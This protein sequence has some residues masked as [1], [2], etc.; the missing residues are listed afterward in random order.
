MQRSQRIINAPNKFSP[1]QPHLY[2]QENYLLR[3]EDNNELLI[4]KRSSINSIVDDRAILGT[5]AK[6]RYAVIEA[7][8]SYSQC[9]D[10]YEQMQS[11]EKTT[12]DDGRDEID[13]RQSDVQSD[14]DLNDSDARNDMPSTL[15]LFFSSTSD[16]T[17]F[18]F[19]FLRAITINSEKKEVVRICCTTK[20]TLYDTYPGRTFRPPDPTGSTRKAPL[21]RLIPASSDHIQQIPDGKPPPN[22]TAQ[23][24]HKPTET[25]EN[26]N[27]PKFARIFP[28]K[29]TLFRQQYT[30]TT[31]SESRTPPI[32]NRNPCKPR[33]RK[34]PGE[35]INPQFPSFPSFFHHQYP[36]PAIKITYKTPYYATVLPNNSSQTPKATQN[37]THK[38][39]MNATTK[40]RD[41]NPRYSLQQ[42]QNNQNPKAIL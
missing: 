2:S 17:C 3:F 26:A 22:K 25:K 42:N 23:S 28:K 8:G 32:T 5:R 34:P 37:S 10:M 9:N 20:R 38:P 13:D 36:I 35:P 1:S 6:R 21:F 39:L 7:K 27:L 30:Y 31:V 11:M 14:D 4:V 19:L 16:N 18:L 29:T 41:Y 33:K 15:L 40:L 24:R 12:I